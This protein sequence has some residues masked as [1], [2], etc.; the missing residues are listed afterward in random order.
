MGIATMSAGA[1]L[2]GDG[3]SIMSARGVH[4]VIDSPPPLGGPNEAW[5]P[6]D[7]LVGALATCGVF[8]CE[9]AAREMDLGL[10][11]V[12]VDVEADF[13]PAGVRGADVSPAI[14]AWR[15]VVT[16][17]GIERSDAESLLAA[18]R[19]RCPVFTTVE[20]AAPIEV[21]LEVG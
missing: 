7:I 18:Y 1:R 9:T 16:T 10:D 17:S 20:Q 21:T 15:V 5:N 8:V 14:Q 11:G 2:A 19:K 3:R 4:G 6:V 13:D 12:S